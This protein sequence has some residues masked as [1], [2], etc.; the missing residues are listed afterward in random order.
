MVLCANRRERP[1]QETDGNTDPPRGTPRDRSRSRQEHGGP[2]RSDVGSAKSTEGESQEV[3]EQLE[4][5]RR[6]LMAKISV[7]EEKGV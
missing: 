3:V 6:E 1:G 4:S 7:P 5:E 2:R